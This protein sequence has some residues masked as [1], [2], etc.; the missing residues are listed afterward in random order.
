MFGYVTASWKELSEPEKDRYGSIYCG[1]CRRIRE[2]SGNVARIGLSY[3]M[4]FLA[5][6]LISLYE[7]EEAR[8]DKACGLHSRGNATR[9]S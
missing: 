6:L 9:F 1:I 8:G 5:A 2:Q 7:P 3:D 4:A